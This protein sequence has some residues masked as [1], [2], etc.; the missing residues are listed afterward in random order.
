MLLN[1]QAVQSQL[2]KSLRIPVSFQEHKTLQTVKFTSGDDTLLA[3]SI[4]PQRRIPEAIVR[5][6]IRNYQTSKPKPS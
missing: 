4:N 3:A 6:A 1:Y 2:T 5:N